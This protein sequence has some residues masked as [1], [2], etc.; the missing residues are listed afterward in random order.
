[1][2]APADAGPSGKIYVT[3]E[4]S[5]TITVLE[6]MTYKVIRSFKTCKRPRGI[7]FS[8][9]RSQFYVGCADDNVIVIYD[10]ATAKLVKRIRGIEE[11]ETFDLSPDGKTLYVSNEE[12]ATVSFVDIETG[13]VFPV[14]GNTWLMLEKSR[15]AEHFE[16]IGN[17]KTHYGIFE[18]CGL[19]VPFKDN[20]EGGAASCC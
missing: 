11:P 10:T 14:C 1:M 12:D 18:G 15:F 13:K 2:A 17:F 8:K 16:F 3:N 4:K 9:D 6:N 19:N 5:S 20:E 7:H